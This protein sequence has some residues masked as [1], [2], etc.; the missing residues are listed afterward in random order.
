MGQIKDIVI[1][2]GGTS[3]WMTAALLAKLFKQTLNITLVESAD[4]GTIGVG[5]ATIPPLQLFNSVLGIPENEFI[6]AT[7]ATFKLGIQFEHWGSQGDSYMHAFGNF[8]KDIGFTQFHHY[9]LSTKPQTITAFWD[10]SLNY[11][12]AINHKFQAIEHIPHS[13][14]A[15]ITHAYHFD[16]ACYAQLLRQYSEKAGVKRIEGKVETVN[17]SENGHIASLSLISGVEVQGDFFID[18]SGF[19]ALLI[20]K[21]LNVGYESYQDWLLCDSAFAVPSEKVAE[22][23]PYTRAIAH[24]AGWQWRI[25]LQHRTGN[26]IVY[27]SRYMSD[28]EA[29]AKLLSTLDGKPLCEPKKISFI[30]GRRLKQWQHNCVAIG[31]SSGFLEPLE[32]TSIHLVQSAIIRLTKLFPHQGV[33]QANVDEFNR[34]SQL[35]F[36]Q[37]RDFIILHYHLN[38]RSVSNQDSLWHA[39]QRMQ[40]PESLQQKITLF[41]QTGSIFRHKEELFTEM[42]WAQVML[43]QGIIP[44]DFNPLA[45][46]IEQQDLAEFF[47][48]IRAIINNS[49]SKMPTHEQYLAQLV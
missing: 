14:L 33:E 18:C 22:I 17:R 2:G 30:P 3:G 26:G 6:K 23:P 19:A 28:D 46:T 16:A 44:Q 38:Q 40:V 32:S 35:E 11:Q 43:G 37:I 29:K 34:Q 48:N 15:G 20:G 36:E 7:H 25:P 8:G 31:L 9:W 41:N 27:S 12:A 10:Y 21:T 47:S 24:E 13:P 45:H 4:I 42:A 1:V 49:V 5:E 39:C